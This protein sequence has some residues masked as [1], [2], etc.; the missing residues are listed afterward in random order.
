M[1]GTYLMF[2]MLN[3]SRFGVVCL[4]FQSTCVI[5][6]GFLCDSTCS[7]IY[8]LSKEPRELL[9]DVWRRRSA[10][11]LQDGLCRH[12]KASAVGE[13]FEPRLGKALSSLVQIQ[14]RADFE[15]ELRLCHPGIFSSLSES[16]WAMLQ[17]R[18]SVVAPGVL[19]L[20]V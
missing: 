6:R 10:M 18:R 9:S 15:R 20:D 12:Q 3:L 19:W 17:L 7:A 11:G 4:Q 16:E 1:F 2:F 5:N 8:S 13:G 14:H